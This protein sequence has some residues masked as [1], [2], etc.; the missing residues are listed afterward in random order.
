MDILSCLV[1]RSVV[2]HQRLDE[3]S[4]KNENEE[5]SS[6]DKTPKASN[7]TKD[8]IDD[9]DI[10]ATLPAQNLEVQ[11]THITD[12]KHGT[13]SAFGPNVR[14]TVN[15]FR[16]L[17]EKYEKGTTQVDP[18]AQ[19]NNKAPKHGERIK[20]LDELQRC[21]E[22]SQEME[23]AALSASGW[24]KAIGRPSPQFVE[25]NGTYSLD[26]PLIYSYS[27]TCSPEKNVDHQKDPSDDSNS[28]IMVA[29]IRA[30]L[31]DARQKLE[32]NERFIEQL[33]TELSTCRAEIGRLKTSSR[34]KVCEE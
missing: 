1:D 3:N 13:E 27:T 24:L 23:R 5:N 12:G 10:P 17:S 7:T 6:N 15:F 34:S 14:E 22:F 11:E 18:D 9:Q 19:E 26:D 32:E 16:N 20:V 4:S 21:F 2:F 8:S 30:H 31:H 29:T 25:A 28:S 33:N